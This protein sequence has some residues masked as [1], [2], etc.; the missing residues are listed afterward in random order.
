[1]EH[2]ASNPVNDGMGLI[3][4]KSHLDTF[5]EST[6][7]TNPHSFEILLQGR[8]PLRSSSY[9]KP[10]VILDPVGYGRLRTPQPTGLI[11]K[12]KC[13]WRLGGYSLFPS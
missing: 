4:L 12:Q 10:Y 9:P 13:I 1:M 3:A 7:Q 6:E 11:E 8:A 5:I 2:G